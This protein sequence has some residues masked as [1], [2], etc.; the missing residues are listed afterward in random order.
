MTH[1]SR[2]GIV[3]KVFQSFPFTKPKWRTR[4]LL[5]VYLSGEECTAC[6]EVKRVLTTSRRETTDE[7]TTCVL[8]PRWE[9]HPFQPGDKDV[10]VTRGLGFLP[11]CTDCHWESNTHVVVRDKGGTQGTSSLLQFNWGRQAQSL[12]LPKKEQSKE[13]QRTTRAT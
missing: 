4:I 8:R 1:P 12:R 3:R 10:R 9:G 6:Q 7:V 2:R 11:L 13:G 5:D